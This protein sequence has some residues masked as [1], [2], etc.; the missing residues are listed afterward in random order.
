MFIVVLGFVCA[1]KT[2]LN[3]YIT[4]CHNGLLNVESVWTFDMCIYLLV[5]WLDSQ[6]F[7]LEMSKC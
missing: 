1:T 5:N 3:F 7:S 6:M 4:D 2:H